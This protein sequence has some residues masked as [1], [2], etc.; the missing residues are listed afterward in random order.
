[1]TKKYKTSFGIFTESVGLYFS[2]IKQFIK[3]M[4]FPIW[5]QISGLGLIFTITYFYTQNLPKLIERYPNLNNTNSLL[6]L[7]L[8]I[9]LPGL[10]I[11]LK[12]FWDYLVAYGSINS[13]LDNMLKSG[14]VYDFE[15][16]KQLI[17]KRSASFVGLWLL[18]GL[19]SIIAIIPLFWIICGVLGVY[20]VLVF[21][22]FTFEED[23]TPIGCFKRSME[24]I[25][26]HFG[27]T[28]LLITLSAVLTYLFIPQLIVKLFDGIGITSVLADWI[29]PLFSQIPLVQIPNLGAI[30]D[31]QLGTIVVQS[32]V[33]QVLI[34][35]TLPLRSILWSMWYKELSKNYTPALKTTK[36]YS[37]K[38]P[39][40][41]LME[42]SHKK[43]GKKQLDKNILKRATEDD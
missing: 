24:L 25:L 42:E 6:I 4:S 16:H 8:I 13:M 39:S 40:E 33:A 41:K 12:A 3:Y 28:F 36:K 21:Q 37:K 15:A 17:Q 31:R 20:F 23:K 29:K 7:S 26:K 14:R 19:F 30:T 34:Q 32:L 9:I 2:N 22:V 11:Y 38:R 1:M 18:L 43:H 35:Y 5:G 10:L 27:M